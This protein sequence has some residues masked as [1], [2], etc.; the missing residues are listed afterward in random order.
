MLAEAGFV[1]ARI[2]AWTGY[3]TSSCTEGALVSARKPC[4]SDTAA[5]S[6]AEPRKEGPMTKLRYV[7]L[8]V[9]DMDRSVAFYRDM[10]GWPL[11]FQS[12]ERTELADGGTTLILHYAAKPGGAALQGQIAGRCQLGFWVDDVEAFH[13]DMMARGT[14][15]IQPPRE[16]AFGAKVAVYADPDGLPFSVAGSLKKEP[17]D[18]GFPAEMLKVRYRPGG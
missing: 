18:Q 3:R 6:A 14:P 16:D 13:Q 17:A 10:L 11:T 8:F 4:K 15:C 12:P 9:S 5:P 2:H 7:T 1:D